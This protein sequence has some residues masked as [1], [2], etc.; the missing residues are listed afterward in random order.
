MNQP[1]L[2]SNQ[3]LDYV[4]AEST[5]SN[6]RFQILSMESPVKWPYPLLPGT[7]APR[8]TEDLARLEA[9]ASV[10][11]EVERALELYRIGEIS[12]GKATELST[13][14]Y[15]EMMEEV[16]RRGLMLSFG[17]QTLQEAEEEERALKE[18]LKREREEA[19]RSS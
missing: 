13:L 3:C 4:G 9:S 8:I 17:P 7:S 2:S 19:V 6:G 16:K 14:A 11:S 12:F 18:Y 15:D 1:T 5:F 10:A